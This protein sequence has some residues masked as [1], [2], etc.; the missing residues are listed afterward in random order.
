MSTTFYSF[1][2]KY[3]IVTKYKGQGEGRNHYKPFNLPK[4]HAKSTFFH[5]YNK[6]RAKISS[7][8][9]LIHTH[10][11]RFFLCFT[12]SVRTFSRFI[13]SSIRFI[14]YLFFHFIISLFTI[15]CF[16]VAH[17]LPLFPFPLYP[18]PLYPVSQTDYAFLLFSCLYLYLNTQSKN[19]RF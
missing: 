16:L 7:F 13:L 17:V 10:I 2:I 14:P 5:F 19:S 18:F 12:M 9:P 1:L 3:F 8:R 11:N 6:K 4:S 15:P